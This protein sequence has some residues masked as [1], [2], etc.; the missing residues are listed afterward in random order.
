MSVPTY[1]KNLADVTSASVQGT[2]SYKGDLT[3][4]GTVDDA[5]ELDIN[6]TFTVDGKITIAYFTIDV[7]ADGILTATVTDTVGAVELYKVKGT[8]V[9]AD[10]ADDEGKAYLNISGTPAENM[11][12]GNKKVAKISISSGVLT[13]NGAFDASSLASF[14]V[15][16]GTT[17]SI[18]TMDA[19]VSDLKVEGTLDVQ[20]N[21]K[22]AVG[23]GL[24]VIGVVAVAENGKLEVTGDMFVGITKA[25][26]TTGAAATV[27]GKDVSVT[28]L[29]YV[30]AGAAVSEDITKDKKS[31]EFIVSGSTW[32]TVYDT[33]VEGDTIADLKPAVKDARFE[34]WMNDKGEKITPTTVGNP[35]KLIAKINENIYS[36]KVI[37]DNGI[38][39]VMIDGNTLQ[40]SSN[41]FFV[42]DLKAGSHTIEYVLKYGYEG[43][44]V[45]KVDGTAI[46]GN[47][48][49]LSGT[50]AEDTS[51]SI[52]LSGTQQIPNDPVVPEEKDDGMG[53]TD[54]LLIVLVV[55]VV[56]L[57]V[58][59]TMRLMRS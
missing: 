43:N 33:G 4:A 10:T 11:D 59:A 28:G 34:G 5:K 14:G 35:A 20:K 22:L 47:T 46:S 27:E 38:G 31:T 39:S 21:A 54:Y 16:A 37:G 55:L 12:G 26:L 6:G 29:I 49:S 13:I 53:L 36:V 25:A 45:I 48:F 30:A 19:K 52:D 17:L 3:L 9:I 23:K 32:V 15:A 41:V 40:K 56:I 1:V 44:V 2:V 58:I 24:T 42:G 18:G 7:N 51:V 57:A 8:V 50:S